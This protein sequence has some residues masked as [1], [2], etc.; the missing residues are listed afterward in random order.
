MEKGIKLSGLL[1]A[2]NKHIEN[3]NIYNLSDVRKNENDKNF[4]IV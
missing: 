2:K 4:I 1:I 3:M